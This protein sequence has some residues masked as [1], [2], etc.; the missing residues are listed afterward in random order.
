LNRDA[1]SFQ[2]F[3]FEIMMVAY[4]SHTIG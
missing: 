1:K 2:Y 4:Y 3:P